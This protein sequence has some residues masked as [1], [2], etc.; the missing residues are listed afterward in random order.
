MKQLRQ[1]KLFFNPWFLKTAIFDYGNE[2][3][4]D[5]TTL[6]AHPRFRKLQLGRAIRYKSRPISSSDDIKLWVFLLSL[7]T[8][9]QR[10]KFRANI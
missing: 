9:Q 8:F 2:Q 7:R 10:L 5:E 6:W 3:I 1:S 4:I